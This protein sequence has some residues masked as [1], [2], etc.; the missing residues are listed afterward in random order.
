LASSRNNIKNT[1]NGTIGPTT[2]KVFMHFII[3]DKKPGNYSS[4]I[5][6]R[7][8]KTILDTNKV[9]RTAVSDMKFI[10]YP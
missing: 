9:I 10:I 4:N 2:I 7:V 3:Y 1:I 5:K 6:N 8:M